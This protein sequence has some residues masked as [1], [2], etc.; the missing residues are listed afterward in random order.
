MTRLARHLFTLCAALSLLLCLLLAWVIV[1]HD[2]QPNRAVI[3]SHARV[4]LSVNRE[5][6]Q[7]K[8]ENSGGGTRVR[9]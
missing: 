1:R 4:Y 9:S 3:E 2:G 8:R 5:V 6:A 7:L